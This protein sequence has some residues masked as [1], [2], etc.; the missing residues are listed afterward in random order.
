MTICKVKNVRTDFMT[1]PVCRDRLASVIEDLERSTD[2][3]SNVDGASE[4]LIETI[5]DEMKL[6]LPHK[7]FLLGG[8]NNKR[9]RPRKPWWSEMLSNLWNGMCRAEKA[10]LRCTTPQD[11]KTAICPEEES[12]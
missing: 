8:S 10:W 2:S 1:S 9:R 11:K 7:T 5:H 12:L 4:L 3:Q 6:K